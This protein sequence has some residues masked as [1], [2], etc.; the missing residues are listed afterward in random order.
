MKPSSF[1]SI[2]SCYHYF[3]GDCILQL[4]IFL[5]QTFHFFHKLVA[6]SISFLKK[7]KYMKH[8]ILIQYSLLYKKNN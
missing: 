4:R 6:E 5:I 3:L 1:I 7:L 2:S 8:D